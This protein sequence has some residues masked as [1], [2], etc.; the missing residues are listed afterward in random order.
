MM[1]NDID[2]VINVHGNEMSVKKQANFRCF[3]ESNRD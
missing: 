2:K 1:H 3:Y